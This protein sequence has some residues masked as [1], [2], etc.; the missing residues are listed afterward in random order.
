MRILIRKLIVN[1]FANLFKYIGCWSGRRQYLESRPRKVAWRRLSLAMFGT[2]STQ[3]SRRGEIDCSKFPLLSF[4]TSC[5]PATYWTGSCT[6]SLVFGTSLQW[7]VSARKIWPPACTG[8]D[9]FSFSCVFTVF[10]VIQTLLSRQGMESLLTL[11]PLFDSGS[12]TFYDLRHL[13]MHS[14]PKVFVH[15]CK[16]GSTTYRVFQKSHFLNCWTWH[17]PVILS[18]LAVEVQ[19]SYLKLGFSK[20]P[21]PAIQ[22]VTF[23][24]HPV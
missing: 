2:R 7:T 15:L 1:R 10:V 3:P 4:L 6:V 14:A 8:E 20:R 23:F 18:Q 21:S 9:S 12:G 13:T 19:M 22:K 16:N 17:F 5:L 24:G 11:L